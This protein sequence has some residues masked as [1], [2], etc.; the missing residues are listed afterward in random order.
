MTWR[1][2][3]LLK[4]KILFLS[5][6]ND[7]LVTVSRLREITPCSNCNSNFSV[8]ITVRGEIFLLKPDPFLAPGHNMRR[9]GLLYQNLHNFYSIFRVLKG[10]KKD[11][12]MMSCTRLYVE[13]TE[14][15]TDQGG[16]RILV[17]NGRIFWSRSPALVLLNY[18]PPLPPIN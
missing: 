18:W 10:S 16:K 14:T 13:P 12:N 17:R 6:V 7:F 15:L 4:I 9:F 11:K 1:F 2:S 5:L 8:I 3:D